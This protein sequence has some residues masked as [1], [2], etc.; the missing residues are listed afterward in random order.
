M[1]YEVVPAT[2][3]HAKELAASMRPADVRELWAAGRRTPFDGLLV[4]LMASRDTAMTGLA[5]GWVV[6]MFG[7]AHGTYLCDYHIPWLL[8]AF[9]LPKHARA[10]L[11]MSRRYMVD[12]RQEYPVLRNWVDARNVQSIRWLGWLGFDILPARPYG[13][14]DLPFH[15]FEMVRGNEDR[16]SE[17]HVR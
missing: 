2:A 16:H 10:F 15:P 4:S 11:K 3:A 1:K 7:V 17:M 5:D 13:P 12:A 6:C 9:D 14:D 8:G